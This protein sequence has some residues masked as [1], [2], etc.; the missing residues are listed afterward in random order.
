MYAPSFLVLALSALTAASP[1]SAPT[2]SSVSPSLL[3]LTAYCPDKYFVNPQCC[4]V[5]AALAAFDC[6]IPRGG[7]SASSLEDF[8]STCAAE[9]KTALCCLIPLGQSDLVCQEP[10]NL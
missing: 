7:A 1:M 6:N 9:K 5:N 3:S 10:Q 4:S 8:K 2:S